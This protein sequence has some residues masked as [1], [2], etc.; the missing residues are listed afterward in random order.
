ML[1][2]DYPKG[3]PFGIRLED[4]ITTYAK[5]GVMFLLFKI[6]DSTEKMY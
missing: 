2:D 5:M 3:H 6:T 4:V 1:L